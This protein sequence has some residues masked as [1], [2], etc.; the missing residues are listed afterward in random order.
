MIGAFTLW[1]GI[2]LLQLPFL[3]SLGIATSVTTLLALAS[4]HLILQRVIRRPKPLLAVVVAAIALMMV[5][6]QAGI[7]IFGSVPRGLSPI[8]SGTIDIFGASIS[9]EKLFIMATALVIA[10]CL[11]FVYEK[12]DIGRVMRAVAFNAE[13]ASLQGINT[14]MVH[15]VTLGISGALAGIAGGVMAPAYGVFPAM[16]SNIILFIMLVVML[17]GMDSMVGAVLAGLICGITQSVGQFFFGGLSQ[18]LV[19][20]VIGV[21]IYL[22]P[23]GLLG[24]GVQLE[25]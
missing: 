5:L 8:V 13:T 20:A 14:N 24:S 25:V 11:F 12:T 23:G 21:I 19:F 2:A 22:R 3:L 9:I 1:S 18:A 17:G 16:G 15:L 4:Y 10:S 6:D 7:L